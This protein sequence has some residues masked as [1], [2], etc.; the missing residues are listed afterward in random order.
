MLLAC[1]RFE[2]APTPT[3]QTEELVFTAYGADV[4][5]GTKTERQS[6]PDANG[7][8]PIYWS[9]G[10]AISLFFNRGENGGSKFTSQ[11]TEVVPVTDFRGTIEAISG[12]GESTGG[13]F[14]FWGIY[15]YS[16][17]NSCDGSSITTVIPAH[18]TGKAGSFADNTFITMA[19]SKGLELGFYNIC[20]GVKFTLT[21]N[22]IREVRI[23]GNNGE[24]IAGKIKVDWDANGKPAIKEYVEGA[25]EASVAAPG[26]GT[27]AAG[28]DYYLVFAP[29]L[30]TDG[31]TLTM[32]TSDYMRGDFVY[33]NERQF[34]RGIF[35]AIPDLDTRVSSWT[36]A[37][38]A[39]LPSYIL[40]GGIDRATITEVN[41][42]V[43]S[44]KTTSTL[45]S[46]EI[47][48]DET[49]YE[50][51]YYEQ[52]GTV[53]NYYTKGEVYQ[54]AEGTGIADSRRTPAGSA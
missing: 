11:N 28:T 53:A 37:G 9:P 48:Y 16:T 30:F 29:E 6:T 47:G 46:S 22:D 38:K 51:V 10:D 41:F 54:V 13:E 40:P 1:T 12:G 34:K 18:Q 15:P 23:R 49:G 36:Q 35:V 31:F 27:F 2:E 39:L 43:N 25:K 5:M 14:W 8:Y 17:E 45:L 24:D 7:I 33:T 44:D 20:S 3:Y 4:E 42:H 19:R 50:P 21:R 26:G 52:S 32:I